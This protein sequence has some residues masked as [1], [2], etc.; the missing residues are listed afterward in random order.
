MWIGLVGEISRNNRD[1]EK[2][3]WAMKLTEFFNTISRH[4]SNKR[5]LLEELKDKDAASA[6][7]FLMKYSIGLQ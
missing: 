7:Y 4:T 3:L 6:T 2:E 5:A 1:F